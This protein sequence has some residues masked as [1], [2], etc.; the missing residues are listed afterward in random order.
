MFHIKKENLFRYAFFSLTLLTSVFLFFLKAESQPYYFRHYETEKGLANNTATCIVQDN[1]GFIWIGTKD[2]L[3]RFDGYNFKVYRKQPGSNSL[4]N[5]SIWK[6]LASRNGILWI[7][8]ERGLFS[9]DPS[10]ETFSPI[11]N[12]PNLRVKKMAEDADGNL[13][14]IIGSSLYHYDVTHKKVKKFSNPNLQ[15][16][17]IL[18][19]L[20]NG[21]LWIG[22]DDGQIGRYEP[23]KDL[24][25]F[26]SL[27]SNIASSASRS[28]EC[29]YDF[30]DQY[31]LVGT[32]NYGIKKIDKTTHNS[33]DIL[34]FNEDGTAIYVRDI[35]KISESKFW[36]G[37]ESG[38][39]EYDIEKNQYTHIKKNN[40]D[41]YSISD[42]AIY[43]LC[44]DNEEGIWIGTYFGG[45]NYYPKHNPLFEKYIPSN[46]NASIHGNA[47]REITADKYGNIWIGSED[48]GLN[49][50][51]Q[52]KQKFEN[53]TPEGKTGSISY[54]NIHGILA[55][56]DSLWIGTFEHG[57]DVMDIPSNKVIK[58]FSYGSGAHDLHSNFIFKLYRSSNNTIWVGTTNGLY[59]YN[60][61]SNNFILQDA[62]PAHS[63]YLS[64]LETKDGTLW[65]S[66]FQ[67]GLYYYNPQK[68][69]HGQLKIFK[70]KRDILSDNRGVTYLFQS[71][72][73]ELW[74]ATE[75]GLYNVTLSTM[76]VREFNTQ[77]GFPSNLIYTIQQDQRNRYWI[78]TSKGLVL[79]NEKNQL[80]RV[81]T[82]NDGLLG[83]QFN[84]NS[85]FMSQNGNLYYGSLKGMIRF[86]PMSL[87][88]NSYVPPIYITNFSVFNKPLA[89]N[90]DKGLLKQSL[91]FTKIIT[92]PYDQSTFSI[93][94]AAINYESPTNVQYAYILEGL[95]KEWN[96]IKN[97]RSVYFTKLPHGKYTFKVRS[98]N[99][100]GTWQN[101]EKTITIIITP[102][103]WKTP[104]AYLW[105][106]LTGVAIL[107]V[108][109]SYY[110]NYFHQKNK[111]TLEL[112][113]LQ[114]DKEL[115]KSKIDFFT[116]IVHEIRT[117]LTLVK[118]PLEKIIDQI[119]YYP[120]I[121][122]YILTMQRNTER[123]VFLSEELLHFQ[124]L[125]TNGFELNIQPADIFQLLTDCIDNFEYTLQ[126]KN[127]R[128]EKH[129]PKVELK[130]QI[131]KEIF[132]KIV[133]N[134]MSNAT[135]YAL[136][137]IIIKAKV[138]FVQSSAG[139]TR[140]LHIIFENDGLKVPKEMA[141]RIFDP[142]FR[143]DASKP[144]PG[145]GIG[146]SLARSLAIL[147][148]GALQFVPT[149]D[150]FNHFKLTLPL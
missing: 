126:S 106:I 50:F 125:E 69:I 105:Y 82:Q 47:I 26:N 93:D 113:A 39:Y 99:N 81:F 51:N 28:I 5:N 94:F 108:S 122:K 58:H 25:H 32:S 1:K 107:F 67:D 6:L 54:S 46:D 52:E 117:P 41:P 42:N 101:N 23:D 141:E 131:D 61:T 148:K 71:Y 116:H 102:P 98:T 135:K 55:D 66:T 123:I 12:T 19:L 13:W 30:N 24:C 37:T 44:K 118:A 20:N 29:I 3:N 145:I 18:A 129:I 40:N 149:E 87:Q 78:T 86:D 60:R 16:C 27:F 22:K 137:T 91:L 2:G 128:I 104:W 112:Y 65:A 14:C 132:N 146:L 11:P 33:S 7:G 140:E 111:R 74:I 31:I 147:H 114:K 88:T 17:S 124:R 21:Q 9:F 144:Q 15:N 119:E 38:I 142:F 127:L 138:V 10:R 150:D 45:I 96:Y 143:M 77:T 49:K 103:F 130:G 95:D 89:I 85:A 8:T 97:N 109:I 35:L 36:A 48:A 76:Q 73:D 68:G 57:L 136:R 75:D 121:Q 84:Y 80:L 134:L 59:T 90:T 72:D 92:L 83:D 115:I 34:T 100:S 43:A 62:F 4:G 110:R 53:F 63:F 64:V 79:L 120:S 56:G 70:N 139:K 133:G